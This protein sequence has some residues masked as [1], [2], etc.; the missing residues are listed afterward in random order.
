ML[1][2]RQSDKQSAFSCAA[3]VF[4]QLLYALSCGAQLNCKAVHAE[5]FLCTSVDQLSEYGDVIGKQ[6]FA[7][8][9]AE[10]HSLVTL[11]LK[12]AQS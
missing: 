2:L 6:L 4:N 12:T 1:L 3:V 10:A 9:Y 11:A 8:V 5:K 7:A